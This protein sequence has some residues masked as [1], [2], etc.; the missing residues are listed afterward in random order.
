MSKIGEVSFSGSFRQFIMILVV[1]LVG[2]AYQAMGVIPQGYSVEDQRTIITT[3]GFYFGVLIAFCIILMHVYF[4]FRL[5]EE[6]ED[7]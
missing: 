4:H 2:G 3:T 6:D 5:D 1:I 7:N